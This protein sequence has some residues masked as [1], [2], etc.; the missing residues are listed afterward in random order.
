[1]A[2]ISLGSADQ[3]SPRVK[4]YL[5]SQGRPYHRP[6]VT[7]PPQGQSCG[8]CGLLAIARALL[9]YEVSR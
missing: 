3:E 2:I 4:A 9:L 5:Q 8:L 7:R 6:V 1:V